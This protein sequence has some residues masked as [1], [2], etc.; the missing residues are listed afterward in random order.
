MNLAKTEKGNEGMRMF[1]G[2]SSGYLLS[3]MPM[4]RRVAPLYDSNKLERPPE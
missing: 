1:D 2:P 3:L 4:D